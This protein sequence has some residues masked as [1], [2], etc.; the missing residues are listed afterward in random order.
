MIF[1]L[2]TIGFVLGLIASPDSTETAQEVIADQANV[3]GEETTVATGQLDEEIVIEKEPTVVFEDERSKISFVDVNA[4]GV[5]FLVENKTKVNITIQAGSVSINGF[6]SNNITMSDDVSPNS[7][8]YVVARTG[9]LIDVG[10][11]E[12]VSGSLRVID[13][14]DSFETY[15]A[16]FTDVVIK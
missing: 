16:T 3:T 11:P 9:E 2:L 5:K 8:G 10:T 7:K 15:S 12:K 4:D 6:S 13:F 14:T 1:G